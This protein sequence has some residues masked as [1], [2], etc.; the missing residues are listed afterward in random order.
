MLESTVRRFCQASPDAS[1]T[2]GMSNVAATVGARVR[3]LR[4]ARGITQQVLAVEAGISVRWLAMVEPGRGNLRPRVARA[5][6][7]ALGVTVESLVTGEGLATI[8][9]GEP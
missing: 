5:L 3:D 1:K 8:L 4:R 9:A 6:A 2:P 7:E